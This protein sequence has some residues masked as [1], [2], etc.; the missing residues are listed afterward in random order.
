MDSR[1]P[2]DV[3]RVP[4]RGELL[5]AFRADGKDVHGGARGRLSVDF[6]WYDMAETYRGGE[7]WQDLPNPTDGVRRIFIFTEQ[8]K[9]SF[10]AIR[11][12]RKWGDILAPNDRLYLN[13]IPDRDKAHEVIAVGW[14]SVESV[15]KKHVT[16]LTAEDL[17]LHVGAIT[18][19]DVCEE[20]TAVHRKPVHYNAVDP[21]VVTVIR[22]RPSAFFPFAAKNR[23]TGEV[24]AL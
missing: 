15:T 18:I 22:M 19:H 17:A 20:L 10:T 4:T 3:D 1:I 5:S 6:D 13:I 7:D 2:Y 16:L 21:D 23:R 12:G 24:A 14:G 9:G 11:L 8:Q